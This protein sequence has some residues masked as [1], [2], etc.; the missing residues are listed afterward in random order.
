MSQ[1]WSLY[2]LSDGHFTGRRLLSMSSREQ[3]RETLALN[4]PEGCAAI[5][6][7][8]DKH[9]QRVDLTTGEVIVDETLGLERDRERRRD[10]TLQRIAELELK[11]ARP[12]R[13]LVRNPANAE[14]RFRID[15][16]DIEIAQL[17]ATL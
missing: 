1:Q 14:A 12:L 9:R 3:A 10:A 8:Y 11:Q 13:E 6:G 4:T 2:R 15:Q 16:I 5:E 7:Q 17:R